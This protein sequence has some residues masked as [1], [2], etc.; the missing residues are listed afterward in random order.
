MKTTNGFTLTSI[1]FAERDQTFMLDRRCL[2]RC[3]VFMYREYNKNVFLSFGMTPVQIEVWMSP[4]QFV[5]SLWEGHCSILW[6]SLWIALGAKPAA[7]NGQDRRQEKLGESWHC[8]RQHP[9]CSSPDAL[10]GHLCR[11]EPGMH[12]L[13]HFSDLSEPEL[14]RQ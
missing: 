13:K 5:S 10:S 4:R 3:N 7:Q 12:R 2:I 11:G 6:L 8:T 1:E 9:A 14:K